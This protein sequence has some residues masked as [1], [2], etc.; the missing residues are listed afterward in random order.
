MKVLY[1]YNWKNHPEIS[2]CLPIG[3]PEFGTQHRPNTISI[4]T[5]EYTHSLFYHINHI[6]ILY[7]T[8]HEQYNFNIEGKGNGISVSSKIAGI[9]DNY[10]RNLFYRTITCS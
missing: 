10:R 6:E 5:I 1:F 2:D 7:P 9:Y 8:E 3:R 4:I